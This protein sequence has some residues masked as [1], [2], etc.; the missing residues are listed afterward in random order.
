MQRLHSLH[1]ELV[2]AALL[3]TM[4]AGVCIVVANVWAMVV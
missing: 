4:V 3:W 1:R 2:T